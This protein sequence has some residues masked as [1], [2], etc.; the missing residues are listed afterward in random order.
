MVSKKCFT[1]K[2]YKEELR[3]SELHVPHKS[4]L[5]LSTSF[6]MSELLNT[7]IDLVELYIE[8]NLKKI[9]MLSLPTDFLFFLMI[10]LE[11][12]N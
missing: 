4:Y 5:Y 1:K 12:E 3:Q 8:E 11:Y 10:L 7:K 9:S 2:H 6:V